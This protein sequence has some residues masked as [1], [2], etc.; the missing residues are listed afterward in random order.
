MLRVSRQGRADDKK[1]LWFFFF[2]FSLAGDAMGRC[3]QRV[4]LDQNKIGA[5]GGEARC[6]DSN[7]R[8]KKRISVKA[9]LSR[10]ADSRAYPDA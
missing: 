1:Q 10:D 9:F 3:E 8:P 7:L 2:F 4:A 6:S 5:A